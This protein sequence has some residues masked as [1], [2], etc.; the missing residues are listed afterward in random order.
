[1]KTFLFKSKNKKC[2]INFQ[3]TVFDLIHF[4]FMIK[5]R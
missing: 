5:N 2:L 4:L 1:M 3:T